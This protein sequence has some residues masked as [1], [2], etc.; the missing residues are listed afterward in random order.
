LVATLDPAERALF[1]IDPSQID[2]AHYMHQVHLPSAVMHSRVRTKP[3]ISRLPSR[4]VRG[5]RAV[6]SPERHLAVFDLENTLVASNVVHAYA[7]L[8]TRH[9]GPARRAGAALQLIAEGPSLLALDRRDRGDFL[10][11][12]YR[13]YEGAPAEQLRV[14]S[15]EM[16][17]SLMMVRAFPA[18]IARVRRHRELGHRTLLITGALDFMIAP[19]ACLFDDVLCARMGE[20]NGVLTGEMVEV[21]LT[22]EARAVAMAG[23]ADDHGLSLGESVAYADSASDLPMLEAVGFPVCVN[24][25]P[26]LASIARR[27]GWHTEQWSRAPGGP[28]PLLPLGP[29]DARYTGSAV[30][31][32]V[33][34]LAG[35]A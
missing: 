22:S 5:R 21:A 15:W 11:F 26:K 1:A 2:W 29:L 14:D 10:R 12:F 9:L 31:G 33:A 24:S 25:E 13:R 8:A 18:G 6:L 3:P 20:R 23:Y 34:Q 19:L 7:W 4:E 32:R 16:C 28:R 17:S 35:R 30:A 27:R